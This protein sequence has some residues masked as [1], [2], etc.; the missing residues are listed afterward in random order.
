MAS[1]TTTVAGTYSVVIT[2]TATSCVSLPASGSVTV[3]PRPAAPTVAA[4]TYCQGDVASALTAGGSNLLWYTSATG[5]TGSATAP[6]P[7]TTTPGTTSYYV[8]ATTGTC[9][10]P[11]AQ[12][13]VTV[14]PRPAAP[15]VAAV[16]YCQG[17]VASALTAGGSNL[18][19]YTS[20]TGGTGSATAPTPS[21]TTPGTTSYYVSAT[22]GTCEG[23]RAQLDVTVAPRPAAPTVAA[24]T[25]CQGDVASALTAGGSNLLWYTSATGGTG[26]ATAPTPSTTTPGTTS[27]YVSAT[28]GTC[29]GPRAQLDV[30]V[31]PRPAAPTVAAVTYCQGDVASA[32]TAGGSNLL[33]YTSATGGTGSATAPTPST[34]TPG[35]TS[36]YVSATTGTCE[37][38]RAQLDVTVAPRPAAPMA[39][40]S[41]QPSCT[42]ATGTIRVTGV[43]GMEYSIDGA[44]Y[45][46]S[47]TFAGL[48]P[49]TYPVTAR[50]AAGCISSA[51]SVVINAVPNAPATPVASASAQPSCTVATGTIRVTGVAGMEYSIDGATYQSSTTFAGLTPGTYPV[52]ARDAAGCISSA[53]SVVIN[54]VPNAPAAPVASASAQPSCTLATG[55]IRVTGVAGMEYSINGATYQSSTTFA[56]LTP[57]TYPVTARDAA[58]CISSAT[59]VVINAVPNA[60]AAPVASAS[61]QPSCTLATGTIRVTGVAGME[62]SIDGATYQSSTTFAGLTPGTYPVTARDAAGCISSATSVVI[63]AVPNAPAAPVAS[64]TAQPSCTVATGTIRVT[65][66]AGMEYSINGATYQSS[67]TF[68]GLTPGT[69][70]VTARDA[71]GCISSAT[72]VVIN[73][74][75]NAPAAPVA[76]ASA[77]PSCTLATGTIRVTGVAGMEYSIDGATYQSS[78]TFAGLTPGTYPVTARDAAGCISSATSVVINAVPNA[79]AAPVASASAQPSCTVATGTIRVTGVAG[80][81]YSINGAT[82]QSSTT[83]AGLTPGTYPVTARDA[84]GCISSATSVVINAVPNAPAAPVASASAQP[85]CTLATGTIRVTGVAGMEYSIDGATY[86]SST[87]FAGLTPGT[88]PVTARDAAGCISSATSVVINAVPNAPAAPVAS[89]SAQPSCTLATG[90]IRVTGVAGMEYSIDGATYQSS[91]TFAGLTPGTYPVTARDAAGCISS[92]TSVV[93]NA[94]PNAPAAPVASASAQPSCTLATGTIRVTGVAGMEYSIDGA[95]YQSSTTFAGLTPGTYPV[96]ARDAAGCISSATS[97]VIN[98]VPNAPAAPVASASAQPSCTVATGTIRVT[99]VAGMEYSINGATYQSSTTFAGLTPGTYPVTARDAAGCISSATSVVINA[100]PALPTVTVNSPAV[101]AGS[102]ATI[103]ATPGAAGAY[104]YAWTVPAGVPAPGNVASFTTT[105]AG[106]YSV[107]ITNTAT[108]CV[109]LPAS[110]TVRVDSAPAAPVASASVQPSCTVATGTIRVTG[111]AGMEYSIDGATYQSSTTFA[112]LTPGTYPVTARNAAGCISSATSVV[113]NAVPNAPAAPVASASVQPSCTVAT[114]TIRVTGVAGMEYSIDG[115]TYQSSTTFAGLTPGTYPVT[116]RDAAGCISSATSVVI[117][118]VPN[119]PAAP[120]ASASAQPSCTLATG[121][122]RVTGVAGMEYSIDGATYQSSTTFAGLTPGTYPVTARDAAGCISSATSVV[123]NAVPNA[124]AAPVAS[125]SAQPSCTLATGTIRVTG[126]AGMEYSIN[127]ATYQSSTTFAGLTPGTYPVTARDAAGCISSA[128]SVVINAVPNAPAAPVASASAQPSCTLATG[129]IRVTGVAGMEYSIDGATYQSS[130]T[131]AGLTPGTYPVTARDAAGCISSATSV[132]I[133]A[134]PNAPAAPVAS[135]SAQ[136]SCTVVTGTIRVTGVAGMEY[137]IDGATYQSSTTFAGL[138]PGTYPVTARDAAGCISSATSVVINAVPNAPAAPVASA[139]AQP[140]CTLATGTIRVTGVAGMEYS[141]DGA[142]YQSSTTFAGLTPGTYPVTARDAAGCIS[143]ATSVVINAVPNAPAAPVASASAQPSC[144]LAT[145]TIRVTGV[146]GMEYSIDGATYQSSTTFAGLTP[147]TYPVTA[148]DAAGCISSATSVVIN[149]VPNAPAA[150]VASASAQP[151]CTVATGTIRVT[152]M[153]GM[154]YS[155]DGATYQ[156]STTFAGLTPGT[157]PVTARDAAGCISS[158]TSVVINAVPNAPAAPVASATAQPSCTVATGTIRVTGVAGMEYSINGATYQSSTTFAGLTPGTYPVTARDAAGCISSA[159]SVVINAVPNAPAAPVAS[160]SAQPSCTVAT[161]TIRVTGVAGMEYSINGATYQS[162]TTFAGLTPGTYPVT[163]RDAAGCISSATSVVINAVPNAPA[164]PVASASAQPSCTVATGTIRV[165]GVAGMEYSINGAT[166]QS[167]TTFAGLTPGTYPV[168]ARDA[169]GCISSA[170]SVVINAV[171][172]APAAPVASAS[173]QPS[174]TVA[175]GTIRVTGV[176]GMEYS[177][178]GA[179][180]QSSTTFAGLT[181]GTYPV[182]ARDAAGCISSATSVVINAVP[183][184]PAA[185]V[186]S[187]SAQPS[188]TVATGTIRVTGMAGMEYSIDGATYQ[189]STTFAGLTPGTYPVTARDAA[190]CISSATSVVINAVPNAPAAPLASASVQPSCTVATGTIRVTGVA[191]MEYSINGATYQSSTTFAG[192]TPGTYPVTA[193]NAAGCISSATS[194]VINAVPNAPA[195]PVASASAQPSC[196]LATGTIRVTGVAGME[197]SIDGATY[198]SSTTFAGLTPGT[199]PV[200]ARD[201]AGCISSATSVVINAVPNAPAAPVASA[202]AQPSCTVATGTIRVTGVA[203]MEYS[204]DGATYQSSTTFAGLTPGTYPVTA[205]DAAGCISSATSV[206]INAA[207]ALPTVTVNSPAVCAGSPATITATPGAAGV[208]N[209]AWTVPAGVPAPGNVASFTT[210]VAGTYSVVITNTATSCVSLPASSTVRVDSAPAAP[211]ASASVQPS[212]TVATGTIRVTG[213]AGMEYSINGATYQSSTTFA[214]LTP[215]TY[216][217]TARN[218]AGCISSATSVVINAVPNAPAA[219]VASASAQPSCTVATGTIR[220][221]GVAGMEYSINGATYQSSTTFAGLTPGTYPVT[222]RDAA[223]CISSATSVVINAVPNAPAAPVASASAQPS[224]TL[225]TGTIRVTGVAGMEY[226][227]NGATYQSSTTFAGLTPGTYPVTARDAAG[228]IS[229]ATSVVINAVPNAPAAPVASASAQPS[230]TVATGTIRVTGVA[231]MEY[232]IDGATYQS[233]TTF[234]GLTPGTYPVTARDAAGCISSATSVVINAAPALPTVTV[235]SPAVCA[236]SPATI[237]A[238]PGAAGAYNY[239]WTVPAGVPAPGNVASFTTTVAGSY[240]VVITNTATSCVS[241]PASSTVRVDSAPAAPVASASVQPSCTVATGT[242]RVT[243]VAG[244]EYSIDGATY[245]SST[246]FAGLTPGTYPVTARNAA[247]CISSATSVVINAVP[248]APAAPV[249]SASVQP[250]CTVATGTIRVTGVAGMEYSINGATY[251]SSTTFAGLTPGTY[252]VT[253][254]DAAGCISSATSVVINAAPALPTVTVNSP[255]VCA[256]SPATITATPG[257][258][259]VY[260]YAWTVPAGAPAPGNVASFTTTVAGTYSVVIT[261]TATSCVSLPASSTVRV[262]SAPA[263]PVASASV[264]P[265]CTVATGTIRVTGVAGMEYS[266][267]GATYQSSTT[268]AGLTPGTYPVTAR[269]AAGCI[270]SAT[271]VVIN[272]VPNA[273]AAPVASASAQPSCTLATGTI[274]VTGVAGMEYSIDGATYQ[275]ST[276]FAGLTPGTYPVTARDAAGCISSATSVVINAVPNAPAAPVA[277][278]SAQPSCTLATGTIRVTGVAGM[279]YSINGATYQSSTTFAGLT[280]GTYPVTARDAAGCIS[281]ATSVVINAAPALP[282]VTVNSPAVCAGSPATITATPGAAGVYNYAWTVPAGVPAPGNVASFTTTVAG[283][284]SVV[285]TNTATSC[286]SLPAS[287]T[288][289]VDSA[290]AAPVASASVQPSCTVA[291]GTI[292]VTGVAGMEYS[293]DGATY[294]SS[295]TFAGLTPGTYPVTA[296]N[297]AGCISSATSV[298]IN[299]VPN[300]PATPVASASAQPSCT[301]ATGTI[302]VTG[303]AGMEYSIDG[304]TYQSSTTFAGLTPGTYPVTARDAAGC[305]SSATSVVINAAPALPTVTVNSPAVCAGSPATITATPGAAGAY[306]YA[307]TVPAGV[308]APGNVASFTTTVAGSYSVVITNTATSCVSLPASSTVRVDSAPAAPVASASVQPSCTVATGTIR[309]TGVAGME[310]SIDGATYQ[311]STTFAGLTPGTYPV[312]ARNA[313]G[314]ISSATSV[315]INAVPN[316][317]AAPVASASAQPSCTVATGTIRVTGV[318]GME[319][320]IDGATYQSSTTFAGLTPGTYPVTARDAAGCISSATSVVI[321]AVPNAPAAPVASASAQPSCT[322][323]TGTIRVTGVAGMEYSINGA[324]YQSSTTFAGLTPGTYPVTARDAAGC[325]SSA[326]SVVI[327]AVPNAPAAP[328]ASASAQPSCTVATGTIRVTGVAGMEYSINGATYQSSTTFAGLTPGTYPVTARDAAGCISSATSV[329]I[330]AVP[331]APAAPVASASAQPSCTVATGTIRVTGVAGMEYSINGATYQSS[332]TFAGLTPGTYPVTARDAAGCISSATSVV[333]NAAPALPTV[334]VNSPAVC[335]G[336]P[337]TITATPGAAGVYNYAWTVPAGAPAPGNVAS[338]T[339]TVA[340]TYSVVITNTATSCVSLSASSTVRVDSAPAAPVAS[341][342]VQ[343]SCTVATGT[344]RVTGVAGM[345]Y[346]INGATYQSSTTFAG[347]T[348]GTYPVTA[349]NAAGC[350]SSATSVVINAVPNAPAAPVASASAQPSCTV[351]TGTI[352]VT[353]VAGMEYSI[354]GATYQSST[355]FAGLTPGTYPVTARDAAGCISS[356]TS[357]VINAVPNAPAAPVASASAQPSCTVATGTIRVTGVA[358]MEYSIDGATYQSS[359]T[360]AGLTPG[361]YP[362]TARDA[363]G[364]ISSATSVVINAAPALPTVTV[365]SPA[366]C[367]GSPATITATPGAAGVYNYAWTVPAGVPAPG[368]VASFT[369]TVAGTYSVV[370]TNTA[371]SCVSLPASST[372]RVDSAPAAPVASASVQPSC[373]VAT[374]TIRVTGVAGMEYSINGATYQSSTTFAGLTPGTYPVTARNAAGCISSATSVVINA[375]P[376]APAAPVASASAQPSCTVAT[377][378]IRVTGVA[379]ME[380]SINGATYQSST[381]FAGLTPGTYPVTARDAAGC[382]SSATSVVINAVP[383]APAAPVASASAQPSCTVATGTIRVTGVAGMEYSINGATYQSSTT[384]AGLTPGTYPVTARDAA[385]CI[386][387]ATSVVINAVPNAPAAP[388]ASASAQPSCTVATGTIRVTG[389]AG[390][391]YSIDGATYQSSTTFAGLTPGTYPVT[392]RDAAGCISSAISVV[393]NAAPALPTVTVNS[394][395]VCAGSPAT[396]TATPGAAG[397]YNYAWTVPAGVPAPG[398]VASFTTTVAGSYSVVITNTATSCVSLPASSTVRVD[399]APAAPVASASVQPSCTVATGTIRVTGVAGMEYSIDGATYQSSTTFAGLT[400]GTYPVT[401]RNAAGCISSATSVVINAVPNAPATPVASASVQPSCTVATGT[402]RVTGV[403]GMEYSIDGATYQSS[404]TF[405][406]L[407]PGTYPVTA[408]DAAGCISSATSVVINAVPNAPAAPVASAS[409]QPSC[410]LAT[411]TIRVTGVAGMEYSINGATYQ[412]STTFAG[413]TPG[414]YPVTVRDAAGCISS[415]TSVVINAVPNAPAAPVASAS[416]QPSCTLATGTIRVTGVA[417]MEYSINGAT[418]QSSTTFAGLTP[419]TYSVTARDAAGCISSAT[420]VVINTAPALP[421]VTVNSPA[422]CA[423]SPATITATPGAAGA[424]NY[425]WTVPAGVPAPGNVASFTTTVAGTYSVVITN[426]ATS[427]VSLPASSTVRVDSAPAAPVASASVQP[428]CTVATGTIRVTGVAGLEYSINGA[429]YQSSTTF[430]G[431]TPGTYPV[432]ARNAAGCISSATSVVIN[433][434]P[435]APAAPV[436]SASAQPSCTVATG[437]IRVT[438]VAGLE[439]SINGATYQ[440]STTF[441]GLTPGTYPVT[442]RD[443]AGCISSATSVVINA[444]PNAPAAPVAS[445]SAQPSCTL[446]TGTIRV[447]GVAGMEYSIDGATYQSSTTFAGLTPGTYPVTARNAAGCIS[448]AT[449][450][451][452]NAVPN[453]PAAPVASASAQPSCTLATGTIRVTGVAGMEYSIDGATYQS[454]T[455]FAGLTPGTYPVTARDAAGCISSATSVVINAVP[456]VPAVTFVKTRD[457]VCPTNNNGAAILTITDGNNPSVSWAKDGA[458]IAAPNLNGLSVG[459]Y[460]VTV[461]NACGS[462]VR[463]I[464]I[465]SSNRAP[466]AVGEAFSTLAGTAINNTV[467][468][469]DS[470]PDGDA[471]TYIV[472]PNTNRGL[473]SL[474]ANGSFTYTPAA[475][476]SGVEVFTYRVTDPC[477]ATATANVSFTVNNPPIAV[478]DSY[479]TTENVSIVEPASGILKNDSDPEKDP[480][481]A[482]LVT[483]T[484]NGSLTLNADGSF[485]Y[486]PNIGFYGVDT[487]TYNANDGNANSN[488]A[489]VTITVNRLTTDLAITKVSLGTDLKRDEVFEYQITVGNNGVNNATGVVATDVLPSE[490]EFVDAS[491]SVGTY[492]FNPA[493]RT[494]TWNLGSLSVNSRQTLTLKVKSTKGGWIVNTATVRGNQFDPNMSNNTSTDSRLILGFFIPNVFTPNRDGVNET[495]IIDGLAGVENEIYIYNRWGNEVYK[496]RNYNSTWNG[497]DLPSAT[498]YYVLKVKGDSNKWTSYSGFVVIMR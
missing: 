327:N 413:L 73:A 295:T 486:V 455:T 483:T 72:S 88:Y 179:T 55:T 354:D 480:L 140:S 478:N 158:A 152:G 77:Q 93:I 15:T 355:T 129:T 143:S 387:S 102:P 328:V 415:A 79:P 70:P 365:N 422:V 289:R 164:A 67:T 134:V 269:N 64:A 452:I 199:Y 476:F 350:I 418:Y 84:A 168:T 215:G 220:V 69:Y 86:Q 457:A 103:T 484:T 101:C 210:T 496:G 1:F 489:T 216:P 148:R 337:A 80:M 2:N 91:T 163:A 359:T 37:G 156:S 319:Y 271:S 243:G 293:I 9:E 209:Y 395:A 321:N 450:V 225:A 212:C 161:G 100:A 287:S 368:N 223:G 42:V 356:A 176:A 419:G 348:P 218:A 498:Y 373:T 18:L 45:Q 447:T 214:G 470:D 429:T 137:S 23:P 155:I 255:A 99:G 396:I 468:T 207:P 492:S 241:L 448:S 300:A 125:A 463:S 28:T 469:N 229:S 127:G 185:P 330:N 281:S 440:S 292:R 339:T 383:N 31:A 313:A 92:A 439:Y 263:A 35:T 230:C 366:V 280:P 149:A 6:T 296:R 394:P 491:A 233:S 146:A 150:P 246:T 133:N 318:A 139:T 286:V 477:G 308:P 60:P 410:T 393:I 307:W 39:S 193:R 428:S 275:S 424:Y 106:S 443:A 344:I 482:H 283:T 459:V 398:N 145:G 401:A 138:T 311:S 107:V 375:V 358:G 252:P 377:G 128:T 109:S 270:S 388:V 406:G 189:S 124:P 181:P 441:A 335:A 325:I 32:L 166:Y 251:Q 135:A 75:P 438:G 317:P 238:T 44:T 81:E 180:Y 432:T 343:P 54:A 40:A 382:I 276:T 51:T 258:A 202:S 385:G 38:P 291:T 121:T 259:G 68:A 83:F 203:G 253:A 191:G 98:A 49:G 3:D 165:T 196:T 213:V 244:M 371:T 353:G 420:S 369:T 95:T 111:V 13:D 227:I 427:C 458:S 403:A 131:F 20:A 442:A 285:I 391:E 345:E 5:G 154:E 265:S 408:R 16:T 334:T 471:L 303:V 87:T 294:Q 417:G 126:V 160:A 46:S 389:V 141:I 56:G 174:C 347:L 329:V 490:L 53:T 494:I 363:A 336:S 360:F 416:A 266:I 74:V 183:N 47:T 171:P 274:R 178:D 104:N 464:T 198:Q 186:A 379:G 473:L 268:F 322:L 10:G 26:S 310:Y 426:T 404:T 475:G 467:A 304:A 208:Y 261:N 136:P 248:N 188:C 62:Y 33:W 479:T 481:T 264:Q 364:C 282:T 240:S 57:G 108:S 288:V 247:G 153:A 376:N 323:A 114:G 76:S 297:A 201:A 456:T 217:V 24:V 205:R 30:T 192:L 144:T 242:I 97:V 423:G 461:T 472:L 89:A 381:T 236:G 112:G 278:A 122:I 399:S 71:A 14:A 372:V 204:I 488:V 200:T 172:N 8:S 190:G 219:P 437:T 118:A 400:P 116:A 485:T 173:A 63:N 58:G 409:A 305:I 374:G 110:S 349:R 312:T 338:F 324:T 262:D 279:E 430:A 378:T 25:Y 221:T 434:V 454:S 412:S 290:P 460:Q 4:V 257:A 151:S 449:S 228:C 41:A 162:S 187:A 22:T 52:T 90:T 425:A 260:N 273:P 315:V 237:T 194:V 445:A 407:T 497:S 367:A 182:T 340:G 402:I 267:N 195:A 12:L 105:V 370:I 177:I 132:V 487:F 272:A 250:S 175:T 142:T 341:A 50:D 234:A 466:V 446:A 78:T 231:G 27:Y 245:Q 130:T 411:G 11:R 444:V 167:S 435:N 256:G 332:T 361:T 351:A 284:Y 249:A 462:V 306:N 48:T 277:S 19:W 43:A 309:V 405:A 384:F 59:S 211:V 342:S 436:A 414:T 159:T 254:R 123:I 34:T 157:Y 346:S 61:A 392:A 82:Y 222:A 184:A 453:A 298:V 397:A 117:N 206:V 85:S 302:R 147:G 235:N 493:N 474:Q 7:S 357:V 65:G 36:Y 320:S 197:Y 333:I 17:D 495:F 115:A 451:V 352:R 232:S 29:E 380:Y 316:A 170:T 362:V 433:A 326:T 21:T 113:I 431:L 465:N 226:S 169:A 331:N 421:T 299:A 120:V 386:S 96:T 301:V 66:V 314:C 119:A 224:C 94:V 390:M 239:A